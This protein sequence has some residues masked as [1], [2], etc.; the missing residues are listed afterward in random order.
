MLILSELVKINIPGFRN[1]GTDLGPEKGCSQAP[2]T[3]VNLHI[4]SDDL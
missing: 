4:S 2:H 3:S 1:I